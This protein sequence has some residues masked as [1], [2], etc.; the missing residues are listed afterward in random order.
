[1]TRALSEAEIEVRLGPE[2]TGRFGATLPPHLPAGDLTVEAVR[3]V[4][5][6]LVVFA[7][8]SATVRRIVRADGSELEI[9]LHDV[10]S[11]SAILWIHG[12]GM[13]LGS[14]RADD[15]L[16]QRLSHAL[17]VSVAAVDYRLAPEH[18][19]PEPLEDC[20]LALQWLAERHDHVV[21]A[22]GSAGGGLA[23]GLALLAR[24]R[25][26]PRIAG[27][28][29]WYPMLDDR[30]TASSLELEH[31]PVWN[32]RLSALGWSSYLGGRPADQY[33]APARASDLDGLPPTFLDVGD[34]DLFI[35]EVT[36][37]AARLA[38]AGVPVEFHTYP[39]AVHAFE[40]INPDAAVSRTATERRLSWLSTI[41]D[42]APGRNSEAP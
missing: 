22:G 16:C 3:D 20:Y 42:E 4:D 13:Y 18:G 40:I 26:G 11:S 2:F 24:D 37:F 29:A 21:V 36:D 41:L 34:L 35:D 33:A 6:S 27:V 1:M 10:S 38:G 31:T 28:Q 7:P 19:H 32:G 12:G 5:D 25:S 30:A 17:G 15:L 23:V 8:E 14:A 9:R 39:A